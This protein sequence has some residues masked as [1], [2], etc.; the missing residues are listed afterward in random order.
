M[1]NTNDPPTSHVTIAHLT[2]LRDDE[3]PAFAHAVAL[4]RSSNSK[5]VSIHAGTDPSASAR[6][7]NASDLLA[8]WGV[9]PSA[10][11]QHER[12]VDD[13][14]D[15]AVDTLVRALRRAAPELV[16]A[17]TRARAGVSRAM[18]DSV[19]EAVVLHLAVPT[20]LLPVGGHGFVS[21]SSGTVN[22]NRVLVAAGDSEAAQAGAAR[23]AWL[24]DLVAAS[25]LEVALVHAGSGSAPSVAT[26]ERRGT[27]FVA[28][29]IAGAVEH[30]LPSEAERWNA[31]LIVMPTRG[32]DSFRDILFGTHTERVLHHAAR[33]ILVVP[34]R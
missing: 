5:L 23:A 25:E 32:H 4:A 15:D 34:L 3:F 31:D 26:P 24:A 19:A 29:S 21:E 16:V 33:P 27:R 30:A 7:P 9:P 2:D 17:A 8:R 18:F 1:Q 6:I 12:L 10:S 28:R 14:C 13:C 11:V 20:L 22:L